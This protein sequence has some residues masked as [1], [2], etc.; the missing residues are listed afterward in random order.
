MTY[1]AKHARL[2]GLDPMDWLVLLAGVALAGVLTVAL[3]F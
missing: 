2:L 1:I 3:G